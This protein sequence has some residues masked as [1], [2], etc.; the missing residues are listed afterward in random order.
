MHLKNSTETKDFFCLGTIFIDTYFCIKFPGNF[1]EI[2][3]AAYW[4]GAYLI[5]GE[6]KRRAAYK[7]MKNE[8][9]MKITR[10]YYLYLC[11]MSNVIVI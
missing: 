4:V 11:L 5:E 1:F 6:S 10:K 7:I 3:V 2:W 8:I 9:E